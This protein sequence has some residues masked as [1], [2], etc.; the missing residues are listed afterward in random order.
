MPTDLLLQ[1]DKQMAA[2]AL[3]RMPKTATLAEISERFAILA[4]LARGQRDIDEGRAV[5]H[6]EAKQRL[7]VWTGK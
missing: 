4:G 6:E 2:D 3:N 1:S 5:T 7:A